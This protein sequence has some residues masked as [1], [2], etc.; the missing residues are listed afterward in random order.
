MGKKRPLITVAFRVDED[1][2]RRAKKKCP[3]LAHVIRWVIEA[4]ANGRLN[5]NV[6]KPKV[7]VSDENS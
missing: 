1:E 7:E 6:P 2:Y 5:L 4:T 3:E